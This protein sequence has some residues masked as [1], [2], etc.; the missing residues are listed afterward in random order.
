MDNLINT[1]SVDF[2]FEDARGSLVQLVHE[3]YQQI[4]VL[5]TNKGVF[6]GGHYHKISREAFF[7]IS[8]CVEVAV[9]A[10]NCS[11]NE[12]KYLFKQGDFFEVVPNTVH[13]MDFPEDCVMV[14]MYD[15]CV[16]KTDGSK[17]IYS[18]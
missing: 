16:E 8:G 3:G 18:E 6:R 7:V 10:V 15:I 13:S 1:L 12:Q 9:Y 2:S 11:E 17:D 5:K 4:N 14:A